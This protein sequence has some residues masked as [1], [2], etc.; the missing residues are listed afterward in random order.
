MCNLLHGVNSVPKRI[1]GGSPA[2]GLSPVAT[3]TPGHADIVN[4]KTDSS[5]VA[6]P[7]AE[8]PV[9]AGHGDPVPDV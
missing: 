5:D 9:I 8:M 2:S 1:A 6:H 4:D 7:L 3:S